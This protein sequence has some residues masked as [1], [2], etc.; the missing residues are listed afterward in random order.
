MKVE[1]YAVACEYFEKNVEL[2]VEC[3]EKM[4]NLFKAAEVLKLKHGGQ[5]KRL[6]RSAEMVWVKCFLILYFCSSQN[7]N[8]FDRYVQGL[9]L[10]TTRILAF[11]SQLD[12][13]IYGEVRGNAVIFILFTLSRLRNLDIGA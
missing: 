6:L 12:A 1:L 7:V 11:S 9:R 10:K 8:K 5:L 4:K 2:E 3:L 13:D